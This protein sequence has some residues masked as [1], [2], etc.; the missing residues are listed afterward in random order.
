MFNWKW[1][2][3]EIPTLSN[4]KVFSLFCSLGGSS[5]GY[6]LAGF[7]V[8]GGLDAQRKEWLNGEN[9]DNRR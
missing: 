8:L 6:K 4:L 3:K 7:N 9:W 2:L 5:M 1:T